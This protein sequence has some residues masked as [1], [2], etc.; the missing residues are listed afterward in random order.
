MRRNFDISLDGR[1]VAVC[2]AWNACIRTI[3]KLIKLRAQSLG[4]EYRLVDSSSEKEGSHHVRGHR[5]WRG[6]DRTLRYVIALRATPA[7]T[8]KTSSE[9]AES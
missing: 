6:S 8:S 9:P 3:E 7:P 4:I 1:V 5:T 2:Y